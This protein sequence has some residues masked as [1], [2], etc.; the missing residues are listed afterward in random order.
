M[1]G[2]E[3][4]QQELFFAVLLIERVILV[5]KPFIYRIFGLD[6]LGDV[7][8]GDFQLTGDVVLHKF[9]EEGIIFVGGKI[10]KLNAAADKDFFEADGVILRNYP[11]KIHMLAANEMSYDSAVQ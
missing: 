5:H 7:L 6:H 8:R 1:A 10:I 3:I 4:G 11:T 9:T 2:H